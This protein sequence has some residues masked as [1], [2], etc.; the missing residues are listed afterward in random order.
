MA[1]P[2]AGLIV[3]GR[4]LA[5]VHDFIGNSGSQAKS[6]AESL[7]FAEA[8]VFCLVLSQLFVVLFCL[9]LEKWREF[10]FVASD[11]SVQPA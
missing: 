7:A 9:L 3:N 5:P 2:R 8:S 10:F 11:E 6:D 4:E 1:L